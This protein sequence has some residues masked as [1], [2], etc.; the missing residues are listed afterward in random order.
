M[1]GRS[2]LFGAAVLFS[3]I[4]SLSFVFGFFSQVETGSFTSACLPVWACFLL[5]YHFCLSRLLRRAQPVR[6]LALVT[7]LFF[8]AQATV[9]FAVYGRFSSTMG[10]LFAVIMWL[11]CYYISYGTLLRPVTPERLISHLDGNIILLFIGLAYYSLTGRPMRPL[12]PLL[13]AA[14]LTMAAAVA[15]RSA[16][17]R[18]ASHAGGRGAAILLAAVGG[19]ALIAGGVILTLSGQIKSVLLGG[20]A[21]LR[22]L[23]SRLYHAFNAFFLWLLSHFTPDASG[24]LEGTPLPGNVT[25]EQS[26][27]AARFSELM[28]YALLALIIVGLAAALILLLCRGRLRLTVGGRRGELGVQRERPH[29]SALLRGLW[30]RLRTRIRFAM[31]YVTERNTAPGVLHRIQR[32]ARRRRLGRQEGETCRQFLMRMNALYPDCEGEL[33]FL[34]DA[35]DARYFGGG[36]FLTA[37]EA[38]ML[39]KKLRASRRRA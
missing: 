11:S 17:G 12:L 35:L 6:R 19:M 4:A 16:G 33:R 34:S 26:E 38:A 15:R 25:A 2:P 18:S 1:N 8:A 21:L 24:T 39:W 29:L 10:I 14:V 28:L 20:W 9:S 22:A 27:Q 37:R 23:V 5:A 13:L 31:R 3:T 32:Q 36:D 7:A 30:A